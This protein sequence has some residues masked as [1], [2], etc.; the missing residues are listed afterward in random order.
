MATHF[1]IGKEGEDIAAEYL[2]TLGY[3]I[4]G[5][6]I[7]LGKDEIDLLAEDREHVLVFAEVKSRANWSSDYPPELNIDARKRGAMYRAARKWVMKN[8]YE[9]GYRLDLLCVAEG[10]VQEHVKELEWEEMT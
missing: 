1:D 2:R 4:R 7:R 6:N 8:G 5:R 9:G 3:K 10:R